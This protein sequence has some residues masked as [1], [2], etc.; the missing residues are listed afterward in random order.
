MGVN[1]TEK[2]KQ[3]LVKSLKVF[4][5][6]LDRYFPEFSDY[7]RTARKLLKKIEGYKP[8]ERQK[9]KLVP[10]KLK[11]LVASHLGA[12]PINLGR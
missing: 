5:Y 10:E 6:L 7:R 11:M 8:I 1:V 9:P 3:V 12:M 4:L 2:E